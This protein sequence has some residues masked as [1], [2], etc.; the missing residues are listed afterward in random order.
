MKS[1]NKPVSPNSPPHPATPP[2]NGA[3]FEVEVEGHTLRYW[4]QGGGSDI[5]LIHGWASSHRIWESVMGRLAAAGYRTWAPDLPG[6]GDSQGPSN[7]PYTIARFAHLVAAFIQAVG[8]TSPAVVGHSM[9]GAIALRLA[10]EQP[11]LVDRLV[12]INPVISGRLRFSLELF[13]NRPVGQ[14]VLTLSR[15]LWT[16]ATLG[17]RAMYLHPWHGS[18]SAIRRDVEDL[19]RATPDAALESLYAVAHTDLSPHLSR[20][21]V[22]TLILASPFDRIIPPAEAA[23]AA[24]QIPKARLVP[25]TA[26]GHQPMD[27]QPDTLV[28]FL[29]D[30]L[31]QPYPPNSP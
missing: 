9:G 27:E 30:F 31:G 4:Q 1:P 5:V 28:R 3:M 20:V 16:L 26:T 6:F 15:R 24:R 25:L 22:P 13:L 21:R 18:R 23:L 17:V 12:L 10:L 14:W 8:I 2:H 19:T 11:E 29:L 7:G